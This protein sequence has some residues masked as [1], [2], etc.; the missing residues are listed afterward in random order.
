MQVSPSQLLIQSRCR[1]IEST[2]PGKPRAVEAKGLSREI[3]LTWTAPDDGVH[4]TQYVIGW[5]K[6]G[7]YDHTVIVTGESEFYRI[8]NLGLCIFVNRV[9]Y[10]VATAPII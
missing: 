1:I 3:Y 5:G 9:G 7:P 10:F 4:V 6:S 8:A 2:R